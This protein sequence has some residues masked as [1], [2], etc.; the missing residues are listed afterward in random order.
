MGARDPLLEVGAA[1][2]PAFAARRAE[3][4]PPPPNITSCWPSAICCA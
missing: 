4:L 2:G 1:L 3:Y